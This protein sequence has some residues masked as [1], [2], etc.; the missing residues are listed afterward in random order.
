MARARPTAASSAQ[1]MANGGFWGRQPGSRRTMQW[2]AF[3]GRQ[4]SDAE[5]KEEAKEGK[6]SESLNT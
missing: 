6:N 2:E 3:H 5:R 1:R 4:E